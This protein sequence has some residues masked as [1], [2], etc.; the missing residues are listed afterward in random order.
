VAGIKPLPDFRAQTGIGLHPDRFRGN[1]V[2]LR[3]TRQE[4]GYLEWPVFLMRRGLARG[5][6]F[7]HGSYSYI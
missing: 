3:T 1:T 4:E 6:G 5:E 2:R 7:W